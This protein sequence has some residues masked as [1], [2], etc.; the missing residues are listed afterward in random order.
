MSTGQVILTIGA[1]MLLSTILVSFYGLVAD[2]NKAIDGTQ[3]DITEVAL[4]ISFQ[5][6]IQG[7]AFDEATGDSMRVQVND[8]SSTLGP[9]NPPPAG[10]PNETNLETFDDIDDFN[11]YEI[12]Q[13]NPGGVLG[14]YR[15]HFNVYYVTP[16]N[17]N[18]ISSGKTFTKRVDMRLWRVTP[19]GQDTLKT[20]F[21]VGY[22]HFD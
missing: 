19:P 1:F 3:G 11:N 21:V 16:S 13:M 10:E 12:D 18:Q 17:I 14:T 4:A 6:I 20:S 9:D 22:F 15:T 5:E 8:L 7:M 2:S